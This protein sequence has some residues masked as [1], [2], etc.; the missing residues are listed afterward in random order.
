MNN[1]L[2]EQGRFPEMSGPGTVLLLESRNDQS[3]KS[4]TTERDDENVFEY[5]LAM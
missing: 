2:I 5:I 3:L 4:K 1:S